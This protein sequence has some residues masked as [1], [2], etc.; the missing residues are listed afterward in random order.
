MKKSMIEVGKLVKKY[1]KENQINLLINLF[2]D[3]IYEITYNNVE[4]NITYIDALKVFLDN[5]MNVNTLDEENELIVL[6][7]VLGHCYD[8]RYYEYLM[9]KNIDLNNINIYK[10]TILDKVEQK[11]KD[12]YDRLG[13]QT[14]SFEMSF[15]DKFHFYRDLIYL[16]EA[17]D[18]KCSFDL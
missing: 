15:V 13:E 7:E 12:C 4:V 2:K 11:C 18:A 1:N 10:D 14:M 9:G 16:L 5:G 8:M 3:I 17:Y 6:N